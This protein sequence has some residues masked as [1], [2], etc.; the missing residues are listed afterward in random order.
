MHK[1]NT[2][3]WSSCYSNATIRPHRNV[4]PHA[5]SLSTGRPVMVCPRKCLFPWGGVCAHD[6][7]HCY[8][9][10]PESTSQMQGSQYLAYIKLQEFTRTTKNVFWRLYI[11]QQCSNIMTHG[12]YLIHVRVHRLTEC[13]STVCSRTVGTNWKLSTNTLYLYLHMFVC[14]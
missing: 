7:K 6:I 8:S 4:L 5:K 9:G 13:D 14:I 2:Q 3:M 11:D 10:T 1:W 12:S